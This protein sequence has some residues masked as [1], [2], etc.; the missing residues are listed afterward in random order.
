MSK[1]LTVSLDNVLTPTVALRTHEDTA[2]NIVELAKDLEASGL[3]T[4][5]VVLDNGNGTYELND[6][7]RRMTAAN[8]LYNAGKSIK[9]LSVGEVTVRVIGMADEWTEAEKLANQMRLNAQMLETSS[10][11]YFTAC[12]KLAQQ[13]WSAK[14]I[15]DRI[16]KSSALVSGWLRALALPTSVKELVLNQ[17]IALN[18]GK[19]LADSKKKFTEEELFDVANHI[20][21]E[22]LNITEATQYVDTLIN[23]KAEKAKAEGS[24]DS[25]NAT[26]KEKTFELT[27]ISPKSTYL[28]ECYDRAVEEHLDDASAFNE[29]KLEAFRI[30][31]QIDGASEQ[32][33]RLKFEQDKEKAEADAKARKEANLLKN[34]GVKSVEFIEEHGQEAFDALLAEAKAKASETEADA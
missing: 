2:E 8:N 24:D 20:K 31:F 7:S 30:L 14:D 34:L 1:Y 19:L 13:G 27:P 28:K 16:N 9:G 4:P 29:G 18:V 6:G 15:A 26:P 10:K 23:E 17:E 11:E 25:T 21:D 3:D 22:E 32:T 12:I 5:L 33:R